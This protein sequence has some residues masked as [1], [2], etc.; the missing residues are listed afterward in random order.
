MKSLLALLAVLAISS[1]AM[2]AVTTVAGQVGIGDVS[3]YTAFGTN[4]LSFDI[5]MANNGGDTNQVVMFEASVRLSGANALL[6]TSDIGSTSDDGWFSGNAI[7]TLQ[8][9]ITA[10]TPTGILAWGANGPNNRN[11][12]GS[13][14]HLEF[15]SPVA[16]DDYGPTYSSLAGATGQVASSE[17]MDDGSSPA[18]SVTLANITNGVAAT[19]GTGQT[20]GGMVLAHF[21]FET[22]S[23]L[24]TTTQ[25]AGILVSVGD[26]TGASGVGLSDVTMTDASIGEIEMA[27]AQNVALAAP[28]PATMGLLGLGL[29]G[30]I[31]RRKKA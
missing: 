15:N 24:L 12:G 10:Q 21:I 3:T 5:L 7:D 26:F 13:R 28:E 1:L 19:N 18:H 17:E 16:A 8:A 2:G 4:Y 29:V 9:S 11:N 14:T 22:G 6:C 27:G 20:V 25:L 31:I 30:L 23:S